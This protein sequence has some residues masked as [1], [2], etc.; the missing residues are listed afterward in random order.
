LGDIFQRLLGAMFIASPSVVTVRPPS[1]AAGETDITAGLRDGDAAVI[2]T[3]IMTKIESILESPDRIAGAV[4]IIC[5]KM[6]L[7]ALHAKAFPSTVT[8]DLLSLLVNI[9]K[10]APT[11]KAWR[12]AVTDAFGRQQ[13]LDSDPTITE[14]YWLP[15]LRQWSLGDKERVAEMTARLAPPSSAGIMFGVGATASRLSADVE[16]Q[17]TLRRI[18]LLLLA[19]PTDSYVTH[20]R[21][22]Q[23]KMVDLFGANTSSSPSTVIK[24][25]LFMLCRALLLTTTPVQ[26]SPLWPLINNKLQAVLAS[27]VPHASGS[28]EITNFAVLQ[29]IKLLDT[30]VLLDPD[31]FQ[32]HEW[33]YVTDTTDAVHHPYGWHPAALSDQVAE[34]LSLDSPE[35]PGLTSSLDTTT[36]T[37]QRGVFGNDLGFDMGDIKAMARSEFAKAVILPYLSQLSITAYEG[38]YNMKKPDVAARRSALIEDILDKSTMVDHV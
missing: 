11:L 17:F 7:P 29:A 8:P 38:V 25:E 10:K 16:T 33:L 30:L 31:E 23:E 36:S 12:K 27:L 24:A 20:L 21:T 13:L 5:D 18:C 2:L 3:H 22:M 4:N 15:V 6:M 35:A 1:A 32:L 37:Q 28:A 26:F 34:S 19:S 9:A 14:R